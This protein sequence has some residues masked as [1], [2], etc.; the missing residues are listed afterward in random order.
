MAGVVSLVNFLRV[1]PSKA[2]VGMAVASRA[3]C[4]PIVHLL[5]KYTIIVWM[6]ASIVPFILFS[7]VLRLVGLV[8][9]VFAIVLSPFSF[10][11][12]LRSELLCALEFYIAHFDKLKVRFFGSGIMRFVFLPVFWVALVI[13]SPLDAFIITTYNFLESND[14]VRPKSSPY[15]RFGVLLLTFLSGITSVLD[16]PTMMVRMCHNQALQ[17]LYNEWY[18]L[19]MIPTLLFSL[20]TLWSMSSVVDSYQETTIFNNT[21]GKRK[22][23]LERIS[24]LFSKSCKAIVKLEVLI[25]TSL[26]CSV[27]DLASASWRWLVGGS[28]R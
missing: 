13:I 23:L 5:A 25:F 14:P 11:R 20:H 6:Y 8:L 19:V 24:D 18:L 28:R 4:R 21:K 10:G 15:H 16:V 12:Q 3:V 9:C 1:A 2:A 7:I 17:A 26:I 27:R 22:F